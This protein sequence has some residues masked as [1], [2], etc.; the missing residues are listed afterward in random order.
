MFGIRDEIKRI[1]LSQKDKKTFLY[2]FERKVMILVRT[3]NT[4]IDSD[5]FLD[6]LRTIAN[7]C[8]RRNL[9]AK[10]YLE[11]VAKYAMEA[12][13]KGFDKKKLDRDSL[14]LN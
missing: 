12:C 8:K 13:R 2:N 3:H 1:Y 7:E 4:S 11:C 10:D 5:R 9:N 14:K 6:D